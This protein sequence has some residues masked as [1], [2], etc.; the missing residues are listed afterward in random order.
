[1][2][3]NF[4]LISE[5]IDNRLD[6]ISNKAEREQLFFFVFLLQRKKDIE[7]LHKSTHIVKMYQIKDRKSLLAKRDE[8]VKL[9]EVFQCRAMINLNPKSYKEVAFGMLKKLSELLS[10]EAYPAVDKLL[11]SCINSAGVGSKELKKYWIIDVDE[12]SEPTPVIATI[13]EQLTRTNPIGEEK[14]VSIVPSK[15]GVHL[16]THPFD[17]NGVCFADTIEIKKDCL[18]NLLI[19]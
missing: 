15:S 10:Q 5:L 6:A 1:M 11:S 4:D 7:E 18:T 8:I 17:T 3:N 2:R 13:Q 12:V 9:C 14:L 19:C 16:I